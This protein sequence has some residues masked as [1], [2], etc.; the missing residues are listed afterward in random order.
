MSFPRYL[1]CPF[2]PAQALGLIEPVYVLSCLKV[3]KY[4]C[5]ANHFFFAPETPTNDNGS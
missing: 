4:R 3:K 5:P 1:N 2:C